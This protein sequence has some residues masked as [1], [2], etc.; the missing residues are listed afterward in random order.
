MAASTSFSNTSDD[1]YNSGDNTSLK[2]KIEQTAQ[3]KTILKPA[4]KT[5]LLTLKQLYSVRSVISETANGKVYAGVTRHSHQPVVIKKVPK[6]NQNVYNEIILTKTAHKLCPETVLPIL[7]VEET[8]NSVVYTQPMF[9]S[10][11]Y[12]FMFNRNQPLSEWEAKH[13]F[14]QLAETILTLQQSGIFHL[15]VKEENIL[16]DPVS[17]N[18][19]LI[20]FGCGLQNSCP[21]SFSGS[22]EFA[23]PELFMADVP[24]KS[25]SKMDVWSFGVCLFSAVTGQTP[26]DNMEKVFYEGLKL[27]TSGMSVELVDLLR[28]CL[29]AGYKKRADFQTIVNMKFLN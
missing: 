7:Y 17:L 19:K 24:A 3:P 29:I 15:D 26:Y 6:S 22:I 25:V 5:S 11:L 18:I 10:S 27:N 13:V 28:V 16:I 12:D 8:V 1:G 23:A 20:D 9:G 21:T 14:K 4:S 2:L